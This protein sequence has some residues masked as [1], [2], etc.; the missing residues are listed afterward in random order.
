MLNAVTGERG[1]LPLLAFA[2]ARLWEKR[3]RS[4]QDADPA[5]L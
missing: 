5:G 3:V 4:A 2:V 1:A